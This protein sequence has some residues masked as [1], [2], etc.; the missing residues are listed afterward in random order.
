MTINTIGR[1]VSLLYVLAP[2]T[3]LAADSDSIGLLEFANG[4]CLHGTIVGASDGALHVR[5]AKASS[6]Q[7]GEIPIQNLRRILYRRPIAPR[8][9]PGFSSVVEFA[10]GDRL[11]AGLDSL[12]ADTLSVRTSFTNNLAIATKHVREITIAAN[13]A[14]PIYRFGGRLDGWNVGNRYYSRK[15]APR[16]ASPD[17]ID[18]AYA[19][20]M[21]RQFA[22]LPDRI[23]VRY[24]ATWSRGMADYMVEIFKEGKGI[25]KLNGGI[26]VYFENEMVFVM[27]GDISNASRNNDN[28]PPAG[29]VKQATCPL[30]D[31][32]AAT[33]H[34]VRILAD[35]KAKSLM[36]FVNGSLVLSCKNIPI[37]D[38]DLSNG[39]GLR[40][41][42]CG[43]CRI[44]NLEIL[45]WDG[46]P[47]EDRVS[48]AW[49]GNDLVVLANGDKV[50]GQ[51]SS[52]KNGQ[53]VIER[54]TPGGA[55]EGNPVSMKLDMASVTKIG[56]GASVG[57]GKKGS[58]DL[59]AVLTSGERISG[60][61][62]A[63]PQTEP[64]TFSLLCEYGPITLPLAH[65][66]RMEVR[67]TPKGPEKVMPEAGA[68]E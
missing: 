4:D 60:A 56:F 57:A 21:D 6:E 30:S 16:K 50:Q 2:M 19:E 68:D 36:L 51:C 7:A 54:A 12:N 43:N 27:A 38:E 45:P 67:G 23:D 35:R 61:L 17:G 44:K 37:D 18:L 39:I 28:E 26:G 32:F 65:V 10:N 66:K 34:D 13:A 1:F 47:P 29:T 25:D 9:D 11:F 22:N 15:P 41:E 63:A 48:G 33:G 49:P 20:H 42:Y 8:I 5:P 14:K 64:P 3:V 46:V 31:K 52:I 58:N 59:T 55:G 24:N 40:D 62:V 53:V